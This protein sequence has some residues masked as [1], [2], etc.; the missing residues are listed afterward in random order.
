[1]VVRCGDAQPAAQASTSTALPGA[2]VFYRAP[3]IEAVALSPSGRWLAMTSGVG[4]ARV[5]LAVFDLQSWKLHAVAARFSDVDITEPAWVN[6][7][8]LVFSTQD[9]ARGGANQRYWPGLFAASRNGG[10]VRLLVKMNGDAVVGGL[11]IGRQALAVNHE[12]L[13]V[14]GLP[15]GERSAGVIVGELRASETGDFLGVSAKWLNTQTGVATSLSLGAPDRVSAWMF[16]AKGQPRLVVARPEGRVQYYWRE[17]IDSAQPSWKLLGDYA[18]FEAPYAPRFVSREG[19]LFVI[20]ASG[21]DGVSQLH[22]FDFA[23]GKPRPEPLVST[24]GFDFRGRIVSETPGSKTL[25][26]RVET[27]AE[28]T[29]WFD[30]RLKALQ[31]EA[32]ARWPGNTNRL[33]C[34]RC[35][36]PDM[37]VVMQSWSDRDPGQVWVYRAADSTWRK[38]GDKRQDVQPA[39]MATTDFTRIRARDGLEFPVWLTVPAGAKAGT[40]RPAVVLVH[41][42]PWVRGRY[43]QWNSDA[44]F[45]ASRG[46]V[47][48]E[49]E[50]R[51]SR[52]YGQKLYRAGWRQYGQAMQDDVADA[53]AWAVKE[54]WAD[55]NKVCIAGASYGGYATLMGLVK[56]PELYRCGVAWVAVTDPL[57]MYTWRFGTD[58]SDEVRQVSYP[59]LIGD[60]VTDRAMIEAHTPVL[61]AKRIKAPVLMAFGAQDRRVLLEHGKRMRSALTEAGNPPLYVEYP[62]EGH[63]WFNL[64][65]RLDFARRMEAFLAQHLKN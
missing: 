29:V 63:G 48:I 60:P 35:A 22:R 39:A 33:D 6:D 20:A 46:Y 15:D 25:G 49:P 30:A 47:V 65:T 7:E 36:E 42:G 9:R 14:P 8:T 1:V 31:A 41:G 51:G 11:G 28:T 61:Q 52:G 58:Q 32:D 19:D 12:L 21:R 24:P 59:T 55:K 16:D 43:W 2:E 44:Q 13:H 3:D 40:P 10:A 17:G 38:V 23:T 5:G 18:L 54:G 37:T 26:V 62:D 53:L 50:F 4:G 27:D 57:L 34:R 56:H 64:E 45:L